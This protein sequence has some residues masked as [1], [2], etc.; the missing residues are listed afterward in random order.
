MKILEGRA[1]LECVRLEPFWDK[2]DDVDTA[3]VE[4]AVL[5]AVTSF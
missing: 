3:P 4:E 2:L 5:K 1:K